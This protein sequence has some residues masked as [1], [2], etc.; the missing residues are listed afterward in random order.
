MHS[1]SLEFWATHPAN[2]EYWQTMNSLRQRRVLCDIT[3]HI[4]DKGSGATYSFPAHKIVLISASVYFQHQFDN[5]FLSDHFI[6]DHQDKESLKFMLDL[7]Y[8]VVKPFSCETLEHEVCNLAELLKIDDFKDRHKQFCDQIK[9]QTVSL[10]SEIHQ[11]V[12][13]GTDPFI[14]DT[15]FCFHEKKDVAIDNNQE[16]EFCQKVDRGTHIDEDLE[17]F[18][19]VHH[20]TNTDSEVTFFGEVDQRITVEKMHEMVNMGTN[21]EAV[22]D[23]IINQKYDKGVDH[24]QHFDLDSGSDQ[25]TDQYSDLQKVHMQIDCNQEFELCQNPNEMESIRKYDIGTEGKKYRDIDSNH[26][27]ESIDDDS[28]TRE[29]VELIQTNFREK[30]LHDVTNQVCKQVSLERGE[31]SPLVQGIIDRSRSVLSHEDHMNGG[32]TSENANPTSQGM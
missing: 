20:G 24:N 15:G 19:K 21:T 27:E 11:R 26:R 12:D 7:I 29:N 6:L 13:K 32:D 30:S 28:C 1:N 5:G 3:L 10:E 17:V 23:D 4:K 31:S 16:L 9:Q 2:N 8:G 25:V 22:S 14:Y 18:K